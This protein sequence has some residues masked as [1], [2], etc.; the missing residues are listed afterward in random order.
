MELK[1]SGWLPVLPFHGLF[2]MS[3]PGPYM[4]VKFRFASNLPSS[5]GYSELCG[6][7]TPLPIQMLGNFH[8]LAELV[9]AQKQEQIMVSLKS[10]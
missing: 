7:V 8:C 1:I 6:V 10:R 4:A 3:V 5:Q 9:S 2:H